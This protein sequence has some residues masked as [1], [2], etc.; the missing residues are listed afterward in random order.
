ME[1]VARA[2]H[3][4]HTRNPG[5]LHLDL[6]PANILL[7]AGGEPRV[8]DFGLAVRLESLSK[9]AGGPT[10]LDAGPALVARR[11]FGDADQARGRRHL[12]LH[13]AGNGRGALARHLD[14]FGRLRS[15]RRPL[16]DAHGEAPVQWQERRGDPE[17]G[18][19]R[20][21]HPAPQAEPRS[22]S[23]AR[24]CLSEVPATRPVRALWL[25]RCP[26]QRPAAVAP[27][28]ADARW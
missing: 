5:V 23:R 13:V 19:R 24:G 22:G 8:T 3:H 14:R 25:G 11:G 2:I 20:Q 26:G 21:D 28:R 7:D 18:D 9:L 12:S 16:C 27:R 1:K 10:T 6:K 17:P 15:R 4:A